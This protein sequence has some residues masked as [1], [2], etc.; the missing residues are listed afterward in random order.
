MI[1]TFGPLQVSDAHSGAC[2]LTVNRATWA[3]STSDVIAAAF[4]A[5]LA[6]WVERTMPQEMQ[7]ARERD[8]LRIERT[9]SQAERINDI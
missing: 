5:D 9:P 8:A 6:L 7:W 2:V 4:L 1:H 3:T